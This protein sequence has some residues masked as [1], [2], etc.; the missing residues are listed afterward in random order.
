MSIFFLFN[1]SFSNPNAQSLQNWIKALVERGTTPHTLG[2]IYDA[3][4]D[5]AARKN[6]LFY[7]QL[8]HCPSFIL[9]CALSTTVFFDFSSYQCCFTVTCTHIIPPFFSRN[10]INNNFFFV[11]FFDNFY[12]KQYWI[13]SLLLLYLMFF[14][15]K[16]NN[17]L[18]LLQIE[19]T[20]TI[21]I[22]CLLL[23]RFQISIQFFNAKK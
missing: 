15:V 18:L 2:D 11:C 8:G 13:I 5:P 16:Y 10:F 14:I 9:S 22:N 19:S 20:C 12:N 3:V 7:T 21:E 1:D 23:K 4:K 17:Q 6:W